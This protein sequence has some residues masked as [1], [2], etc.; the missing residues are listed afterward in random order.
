MN[1]ITTTDE[2]DALPVGSVVLDAFAAICVRARDANSAAS[3]L[4]WVRITPAVKAGE[5]HHRPYLPADVLPTRTE[6]QIKAEALREVADILGHATYCQ[7]DPDRDP[8]R[9]CVCLISLLYA[10][11]NLLDPEGGDQ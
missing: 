10:R 2:L 3:V 1:T 6:A 8:Y 5:H 9:G 4:D 7:Q 11:A